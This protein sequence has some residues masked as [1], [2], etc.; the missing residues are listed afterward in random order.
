MKSAVGYQRSAP[1][2][3]ELRSTEVHG[4]PS[5]EKRPI[6][7]PLPAA[8]LPPPLPLS[9]Q[10]VFVDCFEPNDRRSRTR[11]PPQS[12][13]IGLLISAT[14]H[15]ALLTLVGLLLAPRDIG[16]HAQM[17]LEIVVA[18][19]AEQSIELLTLETSDDAD[20]QTA[21]LKLPFELDSIHLS[22]YTLGTFTESTTDLAAAIHGRGGRA[23]NSGSRGTFFGTEAYGDR[24][25]YV[26]DMS[27]SMSTRC[28]GRYKRTRFE[29][30]AEELVRS[31]NNLAEDQQFYV[32]LF[33]YKTRQMFDSVSPIPR[34]I[35]ATT[36]NKLRLK[37]WI[38]NIKLGS[39]T[40]PRVA[41]STSLRL[42]PSAV[43][44]LSDGGFNGR[45]RRMNRELLQG[46]PTVEEVVV[47]HNQDG[48]PVHTIGFED[49]ANRQRL[50]TLAQTTGGT[51]RFVKG[52]D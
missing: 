30:V 34:M 50:Q 8:P 2:V 5:G 45:N 26:L 32:V 3:T 16:D 15:L 11:R 52:A 7:P 48:I 18:S 33:C 20:D 22:E 1:G 51:Y 41:L 38:D 19:P 9:K 12:S 46:N 31:V 44:L 10:A 35:P 4:Q 25:V 27:T 29:V 13:V 28:R 39:G 14:I 47:E 23:R 37:E 42:K 24:F 6:A 17:L 21:D 43:F 49:M 40:D 36:E